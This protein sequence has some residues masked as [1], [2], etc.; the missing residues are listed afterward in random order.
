MVTLLAILKA[1]GAYVPLD[2]SYPKERIAFM[3]EDAQVQVLVTESRFASNLPRHA[4]AMCLYLDR[5]K[6][7]IARERG[8]NLSTEVRGKSPAYVIYT[9][10]STGKP[11]GVVVTH[12]AINRLVI[13]TNY[14]QLTPSDVMAQISNSSFDAATWEIWGSLLNGA[15]LAIVAKETVLC[16][17]DFAAAIRE[18]GV[19]TMF[20][21]TALFNQHIAHRPE[22]FK[23]VRHVMVGGEAA[24]VRSFRECLQHGAPQNLWN[25]YGPTETT[26]F[27]VCHLIREAPEG[28]PSIPLGR[29]IANTTLY[30]LDEQR[31]PVPIGVAGE[32]YIGGDGV[33]LGYWNRP[34]LTKEKFVDNPFSSDPESKLYR[35]G[36]LVRYLD[37][38]VAEFLGRM[39]QQVKIRGF[40]VE[41]GEIEAVLGQ[42]PLIKQCTVAAWAEA[43]GPKRLH[44]YVVPGKG[45]LSIAELRE[46]LELR[47][48]DYMIPSSF[49]TIPEVPLSPNGKVNRAALPRPESVRQQTSGVLAVPQDDVEKALAEVWQAVLG[50]NELG[51]TDN[52][53]ELGG[54]SLMAVRLAAQIEK[55][56][57][58]KLS[59]ASIFQHPTIRKLASLLRD[60]QAVV[61]SSSVVEIQS[62][63]KRPPIFFVHGVGGGMFWGYTN[64]S[65]HLGEEQPVYAF[66]SRGT[67]GRAEFESIEE[68]AA[69][70]V[71]DLRVFQTQ[72]PYYLGGYCFGGNIAYEMARILQQQ[73]EKVAL[74]AL[75]NS[76]PPNSRYTEVRWSPSFALKFCRNLVYWMRYATTWSAKQRKDFVRWKLSVLRKA[77]HRRL[78]MGSR[79]SEVSN[80]VDLE[81][82]PEGERPLWEAHIR[83]LMRYK[84]KPY[85]GKV[86]L[87]R[88][89]GHPFLC[90]FDSRYGWG[91]LAMDGVDVH[92]VSGHHESILEEPYVK[93]V[94]A[95]MSRVLRRA[96]TLEESPRVQPPPSS[97]ASRPEPVSAPVRANP[98]PAPFAIAQKALVDLGAEGTNR[99]LQN[100]RSWR[101]RVETLALPGVLRDALKRFS[102]REAITLFLT[103]MAASGT[104]LYRH[105]RQD[106]FAVSAAMSGRARNEIRNLIGLLSNVYLVRTDFSGNPT[107]RE[108][109]QRCREAL[110]TCGT[111]FVENGLRVLVTLAAKAEPVPT[112]NGLRVTELPT[113]TFDLGLRFIESAQDFFIECTYNADLFEPVSMQ[114]LLA[115]MKHVLEAVTANPGMRVSDI[116]ILPES[117]RVQMVRHWNATDVDFPLDKS[118]TDLFEAQVAASPGAIAVRYRGTEWTYAQLNQRANRI[119]HYLRSLG[120]GPES[121]VGIYMER[122][123]DV[124][125][126]VLGVL[127]AGG[128][129][130]PLDPDYPQERVDYMIS[131]SRT[132]VLLSQKHLLPRVGARSIR[133]LAVDDAGFEGQLAHAGWES[134]P[135]SSAVPSNLAYVIYTSGSTGKSKGVEITRRSLLNHSLA[136]A[137][138]FRLRAEDRVLQFTSLSFDVSIEE[139]LPGWLNGSM[140]V[141]RAEDVLASIAQ[142]F[143]FVEA[144]RISVLNLPT[145]FWHAVVDSLP[146]VTIPKCVRL[147]VIGGEKPS[148]EHHRAWKQHVGDRIKLMNAYGLTETTITSTV[149]ESG[150]GPTETLPIGR[151][152][153]NTQTYILDSLLHPVPI[154]MPGELYIGGEGVARGYLNRPELT[155]ER[156][157]KNPFGGR[158]ARLYKTGDLARF[159]P[160]GNIELIGRIDDQIKLRGFRI[161]PGEVETALE[162]HPA[163]GRVVLAARVYGASTEKRLVAWFV[164]AA[165][166]VPS[167]GELI[168]FLKARLPTHMIPSS[169]VALNS[170]PLLPNGKVNRAALPEPSAVRPALQQRWVAPSTALEKQLANIWSEVL[171]IE[172][173]GIHD[174]F[175]DLGGH[176]IHLMQA[177]ARIREGIGNA[178]VPLG[179]FLQA[180]TIF[181]LATL[182][183][184]GRRR[185]GKVVGRIVPCPRNDGA[186]LSFAQQ[187]LWFLHQ[188]DPNS[189]AYNLAHQ[190]TIKGTLNVDILESALRAVVAR[191]EALRTRFAEVGGET[192]QHIMTVDDFKL[193][194]VDLTRRPGVSGDELQ[195]IAAEEATK[196]FDLGSDFMLRARL[197]RL[198]DTEHV[199]L[200]TFHHIASDGWSIELLWDELFSTYDSLAA[201]R[202]PQLRPLAIQYIDY[203]QWQREWLQG[204]VLEEQ[205][206]YW[207]KQ[208]ADAPALL[209]LPTD[210]PRP[211][212]LSDAGRRYP[213]RFSPSLASGLRSLSQQ[214]NCT[215]FMTVL[216]GFNALLARYSGRNDVVVGTVV[217]NRTRA[218]IEP[219][220]GFFAN[221]LVLRNDLSGDPTFREMLERT[222]SVTLAAYGHQDLPFE[223]LVEQLH[224]VRNRSYHPLFQVMLVLQNVP[225]A[226]RKDGP[227]QIDITEVDT[228]TALFDLVLSLT[229]E[230]ETIGGYLQ[231]SSDLFDEHSIARMVGHLTCLL[232]SAVQSPQTRLSGLRVVG[233]EEREQL[234]V[235]WNATAVRYPKELTW[236][237]LFESQ[238][239][240]TPEGVALVFGD[241]RLSYREL[242]G[243]ANQLAHHVRRLGVGPEGLVG[244]CAER[245]VEMVVAILGVLKAGG[246]YLPM[247][248]AYPAER[249]AFMLEDA[250]VTVLLTQTGMERAWPQN[251][252]VLQL[253]ALRLESESIDNP[254][255]GQPAGEPGL[256]DLHLRFDGPAQRG[257]P[258]ASEPERLC[259]LGKGALQR[260]RTR[261][262]AGRHVDLL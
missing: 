66:R 68:M 15:R 105:T 213:V 218:E 91:E 207:K 64:L 24:D 164:P 258:G 109:A 115:R 95:E 195:K 61:S 116:P 121:L 238:V 239:A 47:L 257:G 2:Q 201:D 140:V 224:P 34:E 26:T 191:H 160:D 132:P 103:I 199:L 60:G 93:E 39:D 227:L 28:V 146:S 234:V 212:S 180:T 177:I 241:Q 20:L 135:T 175:F 222:R 108:Y 187:R 41:L 168:E 59:V 73:G 134:N 221:T 217:A 243:R 58:K 49:V 261:W 139:M 144:E 260:R 250:K 23:N 90:S 165:Q 94:G 254:P 89:P 76:G 110:G 62:K 123:L 85:A 29:P 117:E 211:A 8:E 122:S 19:T 83:C 4:K 230:G 37:A 138:V 107:F 21:T 46:F 51:T 156:F 57:G 262:G 52:F 240:R 237:E 163:V 188:L 161:E 229:E 100:P 22:M 159:L 149:Y 16:A 88:S 151:P 9:S 31:Q 84:P 252:R 129:Y 162:G 152:I 87:F 194:V 219:L 82:Y 181:A 253:D 166:R 178:D 13:N 205:L 125:A 200:V 248:P 251:T 169:L 214:E 157:L 130:L 77:I 242:N 137:R 53:F 118:Y 155:A 40:R 150:S 189:P 183:S 1:G 228:G 208:L 33:A 127:K 145:A 112:G 246:A 6:E 65:R 198:S 38:G 124:A 7:E 256:C 231:Y 126:S 259:A 226:R 98:V 111:G 220:V 50:V 192:R 143:N 232:E 42:H 154:G 174:N 78:G 75:I 70:Y 18:H 158:S 184:S 14:V 80:W 244:I 99:P 69:Q 197:L 249:L 128:A 167:S 120:V 133:A 17:S 255:P 63:G 223:K 48:P 202:T 67:D 3:V 235:G 74:L 81:A 141:M 245:S 176:S 113:S 54:H 131:D 11:K 56:L 104:L 5:N 45:S 106:S 210:R 206:D 216:A 172:N 32:L 185:E 247:D 190:I 102:H 182:L 27:A 55:V 86:T 114:R 79:E 225:A 136:M 36:D 153:A 43:S 193:L 171:G 97:P 30:V 203:A 72:G 204:S 215:L 35:T 142:F 209:E 179:G 173:V 96:Q 147:L 236:V 44:A 186:L 25:V 196:P 71:A 10:G 148:L 119:A 92:V 12:R 170:L 101:A 233:E